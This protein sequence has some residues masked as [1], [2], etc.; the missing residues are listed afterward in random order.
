MY[1]LLQGQRDFKISFWVNVLWMN[2]H[3]TLN[4]NRFALQ[5]GD[6][7]K[8]VAHIIAFKFK[9]YCEASTCFFSFQSWSYPFLFP[10]QPAKI[11][12]FKNNILLALVSNRHHPHHHQHHQ[13]VRKSN[14]VL[15]CQWSFFQ[16]N[17]LRQS[18]ASWSFAQL[19]SFVTN[20]AKQPLCSLCFLARE[21]IFGLPWKQ[22]V[23]ISAKL[24]FLPSQGILSCFSNVLHCFFFTM[25]FSVSPFMPLQP[26]NFSS[27]GR[28]TG[29]H[30][31]QAALHRKTRVN[32]LIHINKQEK[33]CSYVCVQILLASN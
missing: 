12:F 6:T 22:N 28:Q 21:N 20:W 31:M 29:L 9:H 14:C 10:P 3:S 25:A 4:W 30:H 27:C 26:L 7:L 11:R 5:A 33:N 1:C 13:D 18:M 24:S 15:M 16:T 8:P 23:A 19:L 17:C 2:N 32:I